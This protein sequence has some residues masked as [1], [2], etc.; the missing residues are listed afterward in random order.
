M[1]TRPTSQNSILESPKLDF[2]CFFV[3]SCIGRCFETQIRVS[4]T[5]SDQPSTGVGWK[6]VC[7]LFQYESMVAQET[8][9]YFQ[10]SQVSSTSYLAEPTDGY[11]MRTVE[12]R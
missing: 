5:L 1:R 11:S 3:C 9:V 7:H 6:V 4:G 8:V 12:D 10:K 2:G